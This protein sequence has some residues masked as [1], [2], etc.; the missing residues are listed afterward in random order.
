MGRWLIL[1][2]EMASTKNKMFAH[3]K[4]ELFMARALNKGGPITLLRSM[5]IFPNLPS[6]EQLS[7][8]HQPNEQNLTRKGLPSLC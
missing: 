5:L 3:E 6:I 7:V 8:L 2:A 1:G 4:Y